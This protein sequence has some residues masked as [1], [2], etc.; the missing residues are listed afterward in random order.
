M[1][2][3]ASKP[4]R[5]F[6]S[7]K[8]AARI[9]LDH[10]ADAEQDAAPLKETLRDRA[11]V[12][13]M[14]WDIAHKADLP[15]IPVPYHEDKLSRAAGTK[16]RLTPGASLQTDLK[17]ES[18]NRQVAEMVDACGMSMWQATRALHSAPKFFKEIARGQKVLD[19]DRPKSFPNTIRDRFP[20]LD[21]VAMWCED[22]TGLATLAGFNITDVDQ[23]KLCKDFINSAAGSGKRFED[24]WLLR[25][26]LRVFTILN[27][28]ANSRT[29]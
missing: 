26:G 22:P 25:A 12:E 16:G 23:Y 9:E 29:A 4:P 21:L 18:Y 20:D 27:A 14:R 6:A 24:D 2:H 13:L 11:K 19:A 17:D 28:G 7:L 3:D 15:G 1:F 10:H 8:A 5:Y